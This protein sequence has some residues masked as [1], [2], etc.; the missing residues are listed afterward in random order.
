MTLTIEK[1]HQLTLNISVKLILIQAK[2]FFVDS[3]ETKSF[4]ASNVLQ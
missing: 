3:E 4:V 1:S 2:I